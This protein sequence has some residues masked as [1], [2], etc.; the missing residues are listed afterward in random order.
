M[1]HLT[2]SRAHRLSSPEK[3]RVDV[4]ITTQGRDKKQSSGGEGGIPTER[5]NKMPSSGAQLTLS[6]SRIFV[7]VIYIAGSD[8]PLVSSRG[9]ESQPCLLVTGNEAALSASDSHNPLKEA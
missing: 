1:K 9:R 3:L 5:T 2:G 6:P 4:T 7:F 8:C